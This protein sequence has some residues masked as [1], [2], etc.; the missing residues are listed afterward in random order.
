VGVT[1]TNG[2]LASRDANDIESPFLPERYESLIPLVTDAFFVPE[3]KDVD[4]KNPD[5]GVSTVDELYAFFR[6]LTSEK[7]SK[8]LKIFFYQ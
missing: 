8:N 3:S 6:A 5:L 7:L 2:K 4:A 1:A